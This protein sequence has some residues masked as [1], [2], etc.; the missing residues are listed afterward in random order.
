MK[1]MLQYA[2]AS[3]I[4]FFFANSDLHAATETILI[5]SAVQHFAAKQK[6][7]VLSKSLRIINHR[8]VISANISRID[9]EQMKVD[10]K[11]CD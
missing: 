6:R 11:L 1:L 8:R 5:D 4:G 7:T 10:S 9:S 2:G 3:Q